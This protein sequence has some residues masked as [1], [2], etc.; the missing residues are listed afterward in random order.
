MTTPNPIPIP[1]RNPRITAFFELVNNL[2]A[3]Q[4]A[5]VEAWRR[6]SS[7]QS[8]GVTITDEDALNFSIVAASPTATYVS[9][10]CEFTGADLDL[11]TA[12]LIDEG[13]RQWVNFANE[14]GITLPEAREILRELDEEGEDL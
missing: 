2:P 13:L 4:Y 7:H 12:A 14:N 1:P 8:T 10:L 9:F 6:R 3:D 11:V 5:I